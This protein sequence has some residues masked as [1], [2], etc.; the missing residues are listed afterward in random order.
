MAEFQRAFSS[1]TAAIDHQPV[2][3]GS[4]VEGSPT[5]GAIELG[6]LAGVE[7]GIWEITTGVSTDVEADE[8]FVVLSGAARI[9]FPELAHSIDIG[10]GDIVRLHAGE[11]TVW[12][13]AETLRKAYFLA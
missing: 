9:D 6:S 3:P 13:V 2:P 5:T 8:I 12:T 1:R 7:Y 11:H 10:P 4:A